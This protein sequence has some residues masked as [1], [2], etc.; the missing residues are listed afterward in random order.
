MKSDAKYPYTFLLGQIR[1]AF[2]A[3]NKIKPKEGEEEHTVTAFEVTE[4]LALLLCKRKEDIM[5]DYLELTIDL[6]KKETEVIYVNQP[7][8][9]KPA[10]QEALTSAYAAF[11]FKFPDLKS[12]CVD[13][14]INFSKKRETDLYGRVDIKATFRI[15]KD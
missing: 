11:S 6:S 4:M 7:A 9:Q 15:L 13:I 1:P 8:N 14:E 5:A 12:E 2:E 3:L 10:I